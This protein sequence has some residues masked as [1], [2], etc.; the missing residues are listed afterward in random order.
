MRRTAA[1]VLA[2]SWCI[3]CGSPAPEDTSAV[4]EPVATSGG[5]ASSEAPRRG[6]QV[7]GTLGTIPQRKIDDAMQAKLPAFQRCFFHGSA[8]VE[9][10]GGAFEFYVRVGE[11]GSVEY[12]YPRSSTIGHRGTEQCLLD[13]LKKARFPK[14]Q[15]GTGAEFAWD[16]ELDPSVRAPV[17]WREDRVVDALAQQRGSLQACDLDGARYTVTAY[18]M[19]GGSIGGVGVATASIEAADKIDCIVDAVRSW[20]LPDPGSY[21]AK[22]SFGL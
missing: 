10:L 8:D 4:S 9:A 11:D 17:Q 2:L 15:G 14:P 6:M 18:V 5:E 19:P 12:V 13:I 3:A 7:E 21:P 1:L 20:T 22:V 16:F